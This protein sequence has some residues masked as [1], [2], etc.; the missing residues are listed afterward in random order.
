[1]LGI[2]HLKKFKFEFKD[3]IFY[4]FDKNFIP[5]LLGKRGNQ[6]A[7]NTAG[8]TWKKEIQR[9]LNQR[10]AEN[11]SQNPK[12]T[13]LFNFLQGHLTTESALFLPHKDKIIKEDIKEI[14]QSTNRK[15]KERLGEFLRFREILRYNLIFFKK[16]SKFR[17]KILPMIFDENNDFRR[18]VSPQYLYILLS[19][20]VARKYSIFSN[21]KYKEFANKLK[22]G[23]DTYNKKFLDGLKSSQ[24]I[25]NLTA[26][27]Y[28]QYF[29]FDYRL[30]Q[31]EH[32]EIHKILFNMFNELN[33]PS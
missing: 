6:T 12:W 32:S 17:H 1:M 16:E 33:L 30:S 22:I 24:S 27:C 23:R 21:Y 13:E 9:Y 28:T 26:L 11:R 18:D 10:Q 3:E 20:Y 4:S 14:F 25:H 19:L 15:D 7:I 2:F 5:H 8:S 31:S 29:W